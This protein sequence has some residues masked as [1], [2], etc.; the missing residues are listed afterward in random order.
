[1]EINTMKKLMRRIIPLFLILTL[2]LAL[3]ITA[4][5]E[6]DVKSVTISASSNHQEGDGVIVDA[7]YL[8]VNEHWA[9]S[10]YREYYNVTF[11]T[12]EGCPMKRITLNMGYLDRW[13]ASPV[14]NVD[15]DGRKTM[16]ITFPEDSNVTSLTLN[17]IAISNGVEVKAEDNESQYI[18]SV[19]VE[20]YVSNSN[21]LGSM[22][23]EGS[24]WI[25]IA[26]AVVAVGTVSVLIVRKKKK[27]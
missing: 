14:G 25:I 20:Y 13:P 7:D 21:Q 17:G 22:L 4:S 12:P 5:A 19:T 23:S 15:N 11:Q 1:M 18:D 10:L 16:H 3:G 2:C 24:L 6:E 26:V 27:S 9:L 8:Y